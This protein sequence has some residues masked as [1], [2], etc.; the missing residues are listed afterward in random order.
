MKKF[1]PL[2]ALSLFGQNL[3]ADPVY[4]PDNSTWVKIESVEI[5]G[6]TQINIQGYVEGS[7]VLN[8]FILQQFESNSHC[9]R[10]FY[11]MMEKPG[12]YTTRI[13]S[14]SCSLQVAK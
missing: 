13:S 5:I 2:I 10:S 9:L 12:K 4:A 14:Y 6:S 8:S 1:F 11:M 3:Q 7:T